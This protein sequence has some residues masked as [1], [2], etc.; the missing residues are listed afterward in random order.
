MTESH[1]NSAPQP[2]PGPRTAGEIPAGRLPPWSVGPLPEPPT[3]RW[4]PRS[5]IGPGLLMAGAAIG[6]GEWLM[7][8]AVTANYGGAILWLA[9]ISILTQVAYNLEVM[10]YAMYCG[11][12]IFVGFFR[13]LPGPRFWTAFYLFID[14]FGLWPY[15]ASNAAV[16]L[17]AAMLGHLPAAA[18]T[19]YLTNEEVAQVA[20][21]SVEE[22][23]HL[24]EHPADYGWGQG[25][26]AYPSAIADRIQSE[27]SLVRWLSY[28]IFLAA[29]VPLVFGGKIYDTLLRIMVV[30]I[31]LVLGYLIFLAFLVVSWETAAEV[32]A[33]FLFL[34]QNSQGTWTLFPWPLAETSGEDW[35]KLGAFAAVAGQGGMNNAQFSSYAR[36]RGWGMGS[37]V[38]AISSIVGGRGITL[39]HTG[40]AFSVDDR[41]LGLWRR[42]MRVIYRDQWAIWMTGCVLGMAIPS[43]ISLQLL[44]GQQVSNDA[45]AAATAYAIAEHTGSTALWSL[46]LLCGFLVLAPNQIASTDSLL[47]RWTDV[48]WTGNRSL[49][50]LPTDRV[51]FVYFALLAAYFAWGW[52][53][54]VWIGA[55]PML[56][57]LASGVIMNFI[58]GFSALHTLAVNLILLPKPVRPGWLGRLG[59]VACAVFFLGIAALGAPAV[60]EA[61]V[62]SASGQG[63]SR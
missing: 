13:L 3:L 46:T 8:P 49:R 36:D 7:G 20:S 2:T 52:L 11:E 50:K 59:L 53:V 40:V 61:L 60:W 41:S 63:G 4:G 15:L 24:R 14:F 31:V 43:L 32:F 57:M 10:R 25:K 5:L 55:Q 30:K 34:G 22:A 44:R 33:G 21:I 29:F 58:L 16:P 17:A 37:R 26:T 28:A 47:R 18:P 38:G 39:A 6:G 48:L 51:R 45:M 27:Q 62:A 1:P 42:W 12:P 35:A 23:R 54:L 19:Q 56:L 9:T